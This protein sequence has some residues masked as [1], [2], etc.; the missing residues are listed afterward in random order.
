MAKEVKKTKPEAK[1]KLLKTDL[2]GNINL[3]KENGIY[4][5]I[6]NVKGKEP[7]FI[8]LPL[9]DSLVTNYREVAKAQGDYKNDRNK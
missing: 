6:F 2:G 4:Y 3:E 8:E 1:S 5:V 7:F 9:L